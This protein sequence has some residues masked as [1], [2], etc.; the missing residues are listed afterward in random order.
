MTEELKRS[1]SRAFVALP[2]K[3]PDDRLS[4]SGSIPVGVSGKKI[5]IKS[6]DMKEDMQKEAV[7]VAIAA[8]EKHNV[9]KDV[10]ESIKKVFDKKHGPTWHCIV[11]KNF[12]E[13]CDQETGCNAPKI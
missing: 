13:H 7:D 12:G 2:M 4:S 11:G 8:F 3:N 9:E 1:G 5:V 10:A 6:A